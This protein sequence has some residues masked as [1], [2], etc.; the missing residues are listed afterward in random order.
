MTVPSN[1]DRLFALY[2]AQ[3]PNAYLQPSNVGS[4]GNVFVEDNTVVDGNTPLLP[5]RRSSG[6]FWTTHEAMDWKLFGYDYPETQS[7][8]T[9]SAQ[10]T[11]AQLYSGSI[12]GKFVSGQ[13]GG[14][15]H[16]FM[17]GTKNATY[18]DW[19]INTSAAL[20]DLPPTFVVQFSLVGDFSSDTSTDVGMW[21]I[22]MP[23]DHNKAKR[24]LREAEKLTKR[25]TAADMTMHGT[26]SLTSSLLDQIEAGKLQSLDERDVVPFLKEKLTWKVYSVSSLVA[27]PRDGALTI[28]RVTAH[29]S[30]T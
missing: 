15:G 22:L 29:S 14:V 25:A 1:V 13:T 16:Q 24:S 7:A 26:V 23:M 9:A 8:N 20:L 10:A 19:V 11:V 4:A 12:R 6:S 28:H 27:L 18:T 21:S 30:Q 5:F 17:S 2:Q 3:N